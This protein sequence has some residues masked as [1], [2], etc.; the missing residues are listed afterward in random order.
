MIMYVSRCARSGRTARESNDAHRVALNK[1]TKRV[2]LSK[3]HKKA[4]V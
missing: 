1:S 4:V 2:A 3:G